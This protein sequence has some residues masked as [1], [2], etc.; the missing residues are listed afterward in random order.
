MMRAEWFDDF[1]ERQQRTFESL[2]AGKCGCWNCLEERNEDRMHMILCKVCGNKRCPRANYHIY[3]C[4][5]SNAPGQP[6][7]A[8][9]DA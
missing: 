2:R 4:T 6:G 3:A 5:G 8:Y 1:L 7:S 9:E